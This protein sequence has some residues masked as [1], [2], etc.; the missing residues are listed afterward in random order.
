MVMK[1]NEDIPFPQRLSMSFMTNNHEENFRIDDPDCCVMFVFGWGRAKMARASRKMLMQGVTTETNLTN[2][3]W[4]TL[5][6]QE[7]ERL[8]DA[9]PKDNAKQAS[10]EYLL[11]PERQSPLE[12][13]T[14]FHTKQ[15]LRVLE[16]KREDLWLRDSDVSWHL[17]IL[18]TLREWACRNW[19]KR[20]SQG[21]AKRVATSQSYLAY[22]R[23][24]TETTDYSVPRERSDWQGWQE[25]TRWGR[26]ERPQ[27]WDDRDWTGSKGSASTTS[28]QP[29]DAWRRHT[30]S[31]DD[32]WTSGWTRPWEESNS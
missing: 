9:F 1:V 4:M 15:S 6:Q 17:P 5:L 29:Q 3:Q 21:N 8:C 22:R 10:I 27:T 24:R 14:D 20:S 16:T 30:W 32:A 2:K 13:P 25:E 18:I 31:S 26:H 11:K 12:A 7:Q 28:Y 23:Q 19:R